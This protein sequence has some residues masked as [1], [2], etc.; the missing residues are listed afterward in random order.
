MHCL[1]SR[2]FR[3]LKML[4]HGVTGLCCNEP[5]DPHEYTR[6]APLRR[7][8]ALPHAC[9]FHLFRSPRKEMSEPDPR[10][11][12]SAIVTRPTLL[13]S[14]RKNVVSGRS[15]KLKATLKALKAPSIPPTS[16]RNGHSDDVE[17]YVRV[18]VEQS[19]KIDYGYE[20]SS[21][22]DKPSV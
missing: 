14:T 5:T 7:L 19:V 20:P 13:S 10:R 18:C 8:T 17:F 2:R 4:H 12:E 22:W 21:S 1:A 16:S 3:L 11:S 15:S 6:C 9:N